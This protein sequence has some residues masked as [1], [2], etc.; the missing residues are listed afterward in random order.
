MGARKQPRPAMK[1]RRE[2]AEYTIFLQGAGGQTVIEEWSNRGGLAYQGCMTH[3]ATTVVSM[4]PRRTLKWARVRTA[5]SGK[6]LEVA[7]QVP[8]RCPF[9]PP[10]HT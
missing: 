5:L 3:A 8:F 9:G 6:V 2:P 7:P 10:L 1:A 4:A